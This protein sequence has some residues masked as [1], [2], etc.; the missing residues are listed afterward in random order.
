MQY[1]VSVQLCNEQ[2]TLSAPFIPDAHA[3]FDLPHDARQYLVALVVDEIGAAPETTCRWL[4]ADTLELVQPHRPAPYQRCRYRVVPTDAD[5][6]L[7]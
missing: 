2:G 3:V 1:L 5:A 7:E 4:D 6:H